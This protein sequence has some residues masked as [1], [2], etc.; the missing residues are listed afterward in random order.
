MA[1]RVVSLPATTRRMKK[2]AMSVK[3]LKKRIEKRN[4]TVFE[5]QL[6]RSMHQGDDPFLKNKY[7]N[8]VSTLLIREDEQIDKMRQLS[9]PRSRVEKV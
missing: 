8:Y 6:I 5:R 7:Y 4:H 3:N 1:F 9:K 2:L